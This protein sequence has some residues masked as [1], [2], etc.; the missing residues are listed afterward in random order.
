MLT[1]EYYVCRI[2]QILANIQSVIP[3]KADAEEEFHNDITEIKANI[4]DLQKGV[5]NVS[6]GYIFQFH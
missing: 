6:K 2:R 5:N 1:L 4:N 3:V